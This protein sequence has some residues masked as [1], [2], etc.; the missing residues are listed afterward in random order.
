MKILYVALYM[1]LN[2][3]IGVGLARLAIYRAQIWAL[4]VSLTLFVFWIVC[5][6]ALRMYATDGG[7]VDWAYVIILS[8]GIAV[9]MNWTNIFGPK[10]IQKRKPINRY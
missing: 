4:M 8:A 6:I 7:W 1:G 2:F 9:G 5:S 3:V 10:K